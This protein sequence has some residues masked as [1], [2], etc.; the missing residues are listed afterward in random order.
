MADS[1]AAC[2]S[3]APLVGIDHVTLA[4]RDLGPARE[5]LK[6]LG[7][8]IKEGSQHANG[9]RNAHVKTRS[10]SLELL[11]VTAGVGTLDAQAME[12]V[13][14]IAAGEGGAFLA[15]GGAPVDSVARR[16]EPLDVEY[17]IQ[18]GSAWDYLTF[19]LSSPLRHVYFFAPNAPV[20]D[21]DSV[22]VHLN[23]ATR[24]SGVALDGGAQLAGVLEAVGAAVCTEEGEIT[25]LRL[26]D[27]PIVL[28]TE[29]QAQAQP[30]RGRI[31]GV[32]FQVFTLGRLPA[33]VHGLTIGWAPPS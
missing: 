2:V 10:G 25:R 15:L 21:A 33:E 30:Q 31:R 6:D 13:D 28:L 12:Y 3:A 32:E 22:L 14:F 9:I 26:G 1:P 27:V 24:I 18:R 20:Q 19:P 29:D 5:E 4:V 7:F 8:R 23:G 11:T 16:I 17:T